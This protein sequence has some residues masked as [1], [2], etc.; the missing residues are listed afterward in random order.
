MQNSAENIGI[1]IWTPISKRDHGDQKKILNYSRKFKIIKA[2]RS[3][4]K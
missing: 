1:V 2:Q 3:G 4:H